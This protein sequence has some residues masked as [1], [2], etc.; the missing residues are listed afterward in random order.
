MPAKAL[1]FTMRYLAKGQPE[2][3]PG[4][5]ASKETMWNEKECRLHLVKKRMQ[6][7]CEKWR[8]QA[9]EKGGVA[10][11]Q[12]GMPG[13][14]PLTG[15]SL[16]S[17][18]SSASYA[19]SGGLG[20]FIDDWNPAVWED[21]AEADSDGGGENDGDGDSNN[22]M[23]DGES[24]DEDEDFGM[25]DSFDPAGE[26]GLKVDEEEE[27]GNQQ[28]RQNADIPIWQRPDTMAP[29]NRGKKGFEAQHFLA[30]NGL[31]CLDSLDDLLDD[32]VVAAARAEEEATASSL[33]GQF[34]LASST[35]SSSSS[36]SS[37]S[38]APGSAS[39]SMPT[40]SMG[41][42]GRTGSA[43]QV[44]PPPPPSNGTNAAT[45]GV[46][47]RFRSA[48]MAHEEKVEGGAGQKFPMPV[49]PPP[50]PVGGKDAGKAGGKTSDIAGKKGKSGGKPGDKGVK[51]GK[52]G[53]K[54]HFGGPSHGPSSSSQMAMNGTEQ[55][56][57][58]KAKPSG[59][60]DLRVG[61]LADKYKPRPAMRFQLY[62]PETVVMY[63]DQYIKLTKYEGGE[64]ETSWL[65]HPSFKGNDGVLVA[66]LT[67]AGKQKFEESRNWME[68]M[69][70]NIFSGSNNRFHATT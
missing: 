3:Y 36:S 16:G 38:E 39:A 43:S 27:A 32:P 28:L 65:Q 40:S 47:A 12:T 63:Y 59:G 31:D 29:A 24:G 33:L 21:D 68:T 61:D 46:G 53:D 22:D 14:N 9:Q 17:S 52:P 50:G 23:E 45:N 51:G 34:G 67:E 60:G 11:Q 69:F 2:H 15:M 1:W 4:Q 42:G 35:N 8:K 54:G 48:R 64:T 49:L 41:G 19:A 13:I 56:E 37:A 44:L 7:T 18:L 30:D 66:S 25:M 62:N 20:G 70:S 10:K 58:P 26:F 6:E 5:K 55:S 57:L